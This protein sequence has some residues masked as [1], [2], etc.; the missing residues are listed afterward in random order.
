MSAPIQQPI[1]CF[2]GTFNP[3]HHGHF[4]LARAAFHALNLA[5]VYLYPS[6]Q[7]VQKPHVLPAA[8]RLAMLELALADDELSHPEC[9]LVKAD[10]SQNRADYALSIDAFEIEQD[11]PSFTIHTLRRLR[12]VLPH[13]PIVWVMGSDQ[14]RNLTTW[15]EWQHL[16]DVAH[17]AVAQRAGEEVSPHSLPAPLAQTYAD[18]VVHDDAWRNRL[19]GAFI[20]FNMPPIA[21]SSTQIRA[22]IASGQAAQNMSALSPA[23]AHHITT[24]HLYL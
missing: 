5:H 22:A 19:H 18:H 4:E 24:H 15:F 3:P 17:I 13:T 11:A 20:P 6:G 16:L 14:L 10:A 2:G 23:V 21:V 9:L 8:H 7:P 1:G 12:G